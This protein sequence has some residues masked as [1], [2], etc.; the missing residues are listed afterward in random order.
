MTR[1][2]TV[3]R[4]VNRKISA[5]LTK[6]EAFMYSAD[7]ETKSVGLWRVV[8]GHI[9]VNRLELDV[10]NEQEGGGIETR[11]KTHHLMW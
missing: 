4:V 6:V 7:I 5:L 8:V 9:A 1:G 10:E 2:I 3:A 11:D